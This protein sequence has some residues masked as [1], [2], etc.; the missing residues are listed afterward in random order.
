MIRLTGVSFFLSFLFMLSAGAQ[1]VSESVK[2]KVFEYDAHQHTVPLIGAN[3][4]WAGTTLGVVSSL[5]GSFTI[6]RHETSDLLVFSFTAYES[7]TLDL[8]ET[9]YVE[10]IMQQSISIEQVEVVKRWKTT[11]F[12][13]LDPM[14]VEKIGEGELLK[15]ACC[16]L[17]ESFETNASV[18]VSF[19]DAITG[20]KQIQMLGLAGPYSQITRENIPD[21]RGLSA[22]Y[23]M[24]YIPGTWIESIQLN[25]GTGSVVNGYESIA[26][27][28]NV[29]LRKPELADRMYLNVYGNE[30]SRIEAN[31]NLTQKVSEKLSTALLLHART[32]RTEMDR[33][34][35]GFMDKP[36][37][38]QYILL[39]RWK[40]S[41]DNGFES[42]LGIKAT[43]NTAKGGQMGYT[44]GT[45]GNLWGMEMETRRLEGWYKIGKVFEHNPTQSIGMQFSGLTHDQYSLFGLKKYT[46][47]QNSA[48]ANI[49]FQ[50]NA[51]VY[52]TYK[53]GTS[54]QYDYF[55]EHIDSLN[56]YREEV[57]PGVFAEYT[58]SPGDNLD[59]V[60]GLRGD[61]HNNYGFFITPRLHVRYAM[62]EKS[63]LRF[64]L[65]RG[66]RTAS[67]FAE[68][69]AVLASSRAV[70]VV[71]NRTGKPYGL[72]EEI[73]WNFGANFTQKFTLDYRDGAFS[74]DLYHTRF[75][76]QVVVDRDESPQQ[77]LFYNLEGESFSTS[78]QVQLD[79][80]VFRR[81][82]M[83]IAYR[84]FDVQTTYNSGLM[85]VPM[86]APHRAFM[87]L[88]YSTRNHWSF[89]YTVQ[90]L[91]SKR[92]PSTASNPIE[93]Q[94][95]DYSP[96]FYLMNA[97]ISKQ[98]QEK[99]DIYVGVENILDFKQEDP[100]LAADDP[101]GPYFDASLTWGPVFGRMVYAG[102]RLK[103]K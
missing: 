87:N 54:F 93:Y 38:D 55:R 18:D 89:D 25:K 3:I 15:A 91:S 7:D 33:N 22:I 100:I 39:N 51:N 24:E 82:D 70:F 68:N 75:K 83:R 77:L 56:F 50:S 98:W 57:V 8:S 88:A 31:L 72:D 59:F 78:F 35:D 11:S 23:G 95:S 62:A 28:I 101:F 69:N 44:E 47:L 42:Q 81:F 94:L 30:D 90:R 79:Y 73:A 14:K 27:Q 37:G 84:L 96:G 92:L 102:I 48:Y 63:V 76:N 12:S 41:S 103:I 52:H 40:L 80:E 46:G 26:G 67:V 10:V 61:W 60:A 17:S 99:F 9:D 65:G 66:Q 4:Y 2:G 74:V 58:F 21:I 97:Q 85:Q 64:S 1:P 71:G 34:G 45:Q 53:L 86:T 6:K 16:N 29:E 36:L 20:T 32:Q 43:L 13:L 49:I 5:D 19:T